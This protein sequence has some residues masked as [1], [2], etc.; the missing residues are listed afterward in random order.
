MPPIL[1]GFMN[2]CPHFQEKI[3][4]NLYHIKCNYQLLFPNFRNIKLGG[5]NMSQEQR[6]TA[7]QTNHF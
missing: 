2:E 5:K 7:I 6:K 1:R 4:K 3:F